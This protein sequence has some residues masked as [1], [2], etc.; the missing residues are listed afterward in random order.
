LGWAVA[1]LHKLFDP[2]RVIFDI[3]ILAAKVH[4]RAV[5]D[6]FGPGDE[7]VP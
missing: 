4:G 1:N 3:G 6:E 2:R 7:L 5:L